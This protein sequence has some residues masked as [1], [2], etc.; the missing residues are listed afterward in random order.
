MD[1]IIVFGTSQFSR[2]LCKYVERE[3][4][5]KIVAFTVNRDQFNKNDQS[6]EIEGYPIVEFEGIENMFDP[7]EYKILNTIGYSKMNE[8]RKIK[9]EECI[10]KGYEL[11]S[12]ISKEARVLSKVKGYGNI[13][14]PGAFIGYDVSFGDSNIIY[15]GCTLTHDIEIGSN[16]FFA[17]G[18]TVGGNVAI[19][20]NCFFGMNSTLKNRIKIGNYSLV[21]AG[22]Y[23]N[24]DTKDYEVYVPANNKKLNKKSIQLL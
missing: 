23:I 6:P 9:N 17:S 2:M 24:S 7:S 20:N 14:L 1:N 19:G 15:T 3:C 21:G 18:C 16:T 22:T 13:I 4:A 11:F 12:F 8:I 10:K 5:A